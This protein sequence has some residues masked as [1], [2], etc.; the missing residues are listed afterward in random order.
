MK[1][2]P[3]D[4]AI[5]LMLWLFSAAAAVLG[6]H[7]V[8][9]RLLADYTSVIAKVTHVATNPLR[10]PPPALTFATPV[11]L[12]VTPAAVAPPENPFC[13]QLRQQLAIQ[14]ADHDDDDANAT[15]ASMVTEGCQ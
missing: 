13:N 7:F 2:T 5:L 6:M 4:L 3:I 12:S 1:V 11:M 9:E 10:L 14:Q 8:H 15:Q